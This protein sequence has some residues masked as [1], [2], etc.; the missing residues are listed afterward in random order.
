MPMADWMLA[1]GAFILAAALSSWATLLMLPWLRRVCAGQHV[2]EDVPETHLEKAG[3]PSMGGIPMLLG[4][5]LAA[6][7]FLAVADCLTVQFWACAL[8]VVGFALV[9]LADDARK[10]GNVK[11]KGILARYRILA[12]VLIAGAFLYLLQTR[13]EAPEHPWWMG[14][15]AWPLGIAVAFRL[16]VIL[17][18]GNA[19]N[20]TD[21]LDG[22]AAGLTAIASVALG[23]ICLWM[24]SLELGVWAMALGGGAAGFLILNAKPASIWMGDVGSLGLGAALASIAVSAGIEIIYA[25]A[26]LVFVAEAGSVILQVISFKS[27]GKRIFRMSPLHHHFELCGMKEQAVVSRFWMAGLIFGAMA[28]GVFAMARG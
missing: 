3:T 12:E 19:L 26:G 9:G 5:L 8:L 1:A 24:G 20:L 25:I 23:S 4:T 21:G 17:G 15:A 28:V 14:S 18:S 2:R 16:F 11:S 10:L 13:T 6:L 22:L 27:T 7:I